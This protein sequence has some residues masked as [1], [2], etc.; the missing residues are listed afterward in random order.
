MNDRVSLKQIWFQNR[1]SKSRQC[2][3]TSHQSIPGSLLALLSCEDPLTTVHFPESYSPSVPDCPEFSAASF[4]ADAA[5][6][7]FASAADLIDWPVPP[8]PAYSEIPPV[9]MET[10]P[11]QSIPLDSLASTA[12]L[13]NWPVP[14]TPAYS[15]VAMETTMPF[16]QISQHSFTSPSA[17]LDSVTMANMLMNDGTPSDSAHVRNL[18]RTDEEM[19]ACRVR[20]L[21]TPEPTWCGVKLSRRRAFSF[22][23]QC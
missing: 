1:R 11:I 7:I 5:P 8:T 15:S 16:C 4:N 9:A 12:D 13:R 14:P 22:V 20:T 17:A 3:V 6:H 2:H 23:R 19:T 10:R 18:F 21:Q